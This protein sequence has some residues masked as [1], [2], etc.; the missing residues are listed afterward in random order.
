MKYEE[1]CIS[2]LFTIL[3]ILW[4]TRPGIGNIPEWSSFFKSK[5]PTDGTSAILVSFTLFIFPIRN[6]PLKD[7]GEEDEKAESIMDWSEMKRFPWDVILFLGG[8]FAL[9][10]AFEISGL[11]KSSQN[12][13]YL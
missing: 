10:D 6:Y 5:F 12:N 3:I 7:N 13:L 8:G 11:S 2:I 4:T 1:Y 9:A